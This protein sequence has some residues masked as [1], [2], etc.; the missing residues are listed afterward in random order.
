MQ[1]GEVQVGWV[2]GTVSDHRLGGRAQAVKGQRWPHWRVRPRVL[3]CHKPESS[4]FSEPS[5]TPLEQTFQPFSWVV[6]VFM[7]LPL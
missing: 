1:V 2:H 7:P 6:C 3:L 4:A 5:A